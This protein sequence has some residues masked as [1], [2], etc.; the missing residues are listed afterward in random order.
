MAKVAMQQGDLGNQAIALTVP[1]ENTHMVAGQE[2][3]QNLEQTKTW[4]HRP[5]LLKHVDWLNMGTQGAGNREGLK[6]KHK[7]KDHKTS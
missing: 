4:A 6:G 1:M 3:R 7:L 2:H 5:S